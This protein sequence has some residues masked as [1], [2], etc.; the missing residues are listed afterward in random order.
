MKKI[1]RR[2]VHPNLPSLTQARDYKSEKVEVFSN[3]FLLP[4]FIRE[5]R[6]ANNTK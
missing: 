6:E 2:Q 5:E 1:A 4:L 3:N